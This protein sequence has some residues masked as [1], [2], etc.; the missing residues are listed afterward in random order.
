MK[1]FTFGKY[2]GLQISDPAV[3]TEY[4]LW[5]KERYKRDLVDIEGELDRRELASYGNLSWAEKI[6]EAGFRS[7]ALKHHP[8]HGGT[9]DDMREILGAKEQ[10]ANM[11]KSSGRRY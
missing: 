3:E 7:L 9:N 10:M 2:N 11:L 4:L 1:T 6:L 8:D 5:L